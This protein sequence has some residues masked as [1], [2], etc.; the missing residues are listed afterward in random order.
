VP[1]QALGAHWAAG[2]V[3]PVTLAAV[4]AYGTA[5]IGPDPR[6]VA[7]GPIDIRT[8]WWLDHTATLGST[9]VLIAFAVAGA[10]GWSGEPYPAL[11]VPALSG[12][13]VAVAAA[14]VMVARFGSGP[15]LALGTAPTVTA[16][17]II[18]PY[19]P[20]G[21]ATVAIDPTLHHWT[22][23]ESARGPSTST[24]AAVWTVAA[25]AAVMAARRFPADVARLSWLTREAIDDQHS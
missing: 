16:A 11:L 2:W 24:G 25:V 23:S 7:S 21:L 13:A 4:L 15:G 3:L 5:R 18:V 9:V 12:G 17:I 1:P 14:H 22:H 8:R 10:A 6:L 20:A 19:W